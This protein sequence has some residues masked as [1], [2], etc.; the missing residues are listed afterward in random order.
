MKN[1]IPPFLKTKAVFRD[2][3]VPKRQP[4]YVSYYQGHVSS[5][6]WYTYGGLIRESNHWS[7]IVGYSEGTLCCGLGQGYWVLKTRKKSGNPFKCG[8]CKWSHFEW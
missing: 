3:K 1:K 7:A 6:Y 4:D 5:R 2:C 8:K